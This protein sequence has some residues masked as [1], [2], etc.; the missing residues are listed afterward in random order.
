MHSNSYCNNLT[1]TKQKTQ[2]IYLK[3]KEFKLN[4]YVIKQNK[5][6]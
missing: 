6:K 1:K 4:N 2:K 5:T 3:D